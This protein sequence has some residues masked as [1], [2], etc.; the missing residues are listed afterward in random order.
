MATIATGCRGIGTAPPDQAS[1]LR[2]LVEAMSGATLPHAAA[3]HGRRQVPVVAIASGKGGVGKTNLAVNLAIAM[4]RRGHRTTLL[5]ADLGMANADVLCGL[6]P[7]RRLDTVLRDDRGPGLGSCIVEAPGGFLLVPGAVG[8]AR[9]ADLEASVRQRLVSGLAELESRS[10]T[11]LID[12]GAGIGRDV[13]SFARAAD[14]LL[15]VVTPEPTSITDAY[16]LIK[17]VIDRANGP[18]CVTP[19]ICLVL[20]NVS[21]EHEARAVSARLTG[22]CERFL[23][24]APEVL[25]AIRHDRRV[26]RAVRDRRPHLLGFP[27]CRASRDVDALAARLLGMSR[28]GSPLADRLG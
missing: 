15:V 26:L 19:R 28:V 23:C 1:R 10:D 13:M 24:F 17:C 5:D 18:A 14:R 2:A 4:A 20:N 21:S 27:R 25:G 7:G 6:S 12:T 22:A 3:S 16:G 11:V 8:V 9:V